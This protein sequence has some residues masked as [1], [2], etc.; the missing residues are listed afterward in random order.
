MFVKLMFPRGIN[1]ICLSFA[2]ALAFALGEA[3][4]RP[5]T[6]SA[7]FGDRHGWTPV[8]PSGMFGVGGVGSTLSDPGTIGRLTAA[9]LSGT[10]FEISLWEIYKTKKKPYFRSLDRILEKMQDTGVHPIGVIF[11]TPPSLGEKK[12]SPPRDVWRWGQLAASVVAHVNENFPGLMTDYEIWNEP[13]LAESLCARD[14]A[15]RLDSYVSMFAAAS[16]A[17]HTQAELDG[18]PIRTG[19]PVISRMAFAPVWIPTLLD[20]PGTAPYVDFVSFHLYVT[21]QPDIDKKMNWAHLYSITQSGTQGLIHYYNVIEALVRAGHQPHPA[22]TPI[23]ITEYNDNWAYS[24]DCCRNHPTFAPLWNSLAVSDLLNVVY[25]GASTVPNRLMYFNAAGPPF[26][27]MGEWNSKMDCNPS[28]A[29]P[30]PQFYAYALFASPDY[31]DLQAGG[32]MAASVTPA[33][34]T[35]GLTAT[36]FYTNKADSV[37]VINPSSRDYGAVKINLINPG[38]TSETGEAYL[39]NSS[40]G[41]ITSEPVTLNWISG[42]YS[43]TVNLPGYSIV[44]L[45]IKG[46][47][48]GSAPSAALTVTP[49]SGRHPLTVDIDSSQSQRGGSYIIGRTID[50]GDGRWLNWTPTTSYTYKKAGTYTIRLSVRNQS[51]QLSTTSEV[52]TVH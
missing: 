31:L 25:S 34:T 44:A 2:L 43:A 26:C 33:S 10:R 42:G 23:Y 32:H 9:G 7:D 40:H 50:F 28:V 16:S 11:G 15:A 30:Y 3:V 24:A 39:L 49:K 27:I 14:D 6:V 48:A 1:R 45:S 5:Q 4:A 17:M 29:E 22:S 21:G 51:G 41:W 19:G 38:L 18:Q 20:N 8:V 35:G 12:C 36:A 13:E 37:V 52:V 46:G 47:P